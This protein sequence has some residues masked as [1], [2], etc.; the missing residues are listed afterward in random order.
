MDDTSNDKPTD[1][2]LA[3]RAAAGDR[4]ARGALVARHRDRMYRLAARVLGDADAAGGLAQEVS[5][6]LPA[7]LASWRGESK[8]TT[9]LNRAVVSAAVDTLA[10]RA[11]ANDRDAYEA[12]VNYLYEPVYVDAC[13]RLPRPRRPAKRR[14]RAPRPVLCLAP[15]DADD[16]RNDLFE[17]LPEILADWHGQG[18]FF[19]WL[20][21]SVDYGVLDKWS[22][23]HR[24]RRN[25]E[26][27]RRRSFRPLGEVDGRGH[28]QR[29]NPERDTRWHDLMRDEADERE[30]KAAD[31][32]RMIEQLW[33]R[34]EL[35]DELWRT[36]YL[37]LKM[38]LSHAEAG[39]VLGAPEGTVSYRMSE[40]R[41]R[42][43]GL[44]GGE[45]EEQ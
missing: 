36:A 24:Q 28:R 37:V 29:R 5:E 27:Y 11:A 1:E 44:D 38:G 16:L 17:K 15:F 32:W 2:T 42:L 35:S 26:R 31:L 10:H 3:R 41:K 21:L 22:R 19:S 4:D 45:E 18:E 39:K 13:R 30:R 34:G 33:K 40:L 9:W 23:D 8:F 6:K 7:K 43:R 20:E 12:L 25:I 14:P